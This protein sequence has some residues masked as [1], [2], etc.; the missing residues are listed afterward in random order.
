MISG[1]LSWIGRR[2]LLDGA[3]SGAICEP[4]A[5]DALQRFGSTR[6]IAVTERNAVA[7]AKIVLRQIAVQVLL[8]AMLVDAL[9][10]AL[11]NRVVA[12]D[13]QLAFSRIAFDLCLNR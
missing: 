10:A 1:N 6:I 8:T 7:V 12:L 4:L 9:H 11:E 3:I 13:R 5:D 2:H